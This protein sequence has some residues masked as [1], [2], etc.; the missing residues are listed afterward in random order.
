MSDSRGDQADILGASRS[1]RWLVTGGSGLLGSN[2]ARLLSESGE[3]VCSARTMPPKSPFPFLTANLED[4][5]SRDG[6]VSRARATA[7]FHAGA[8]ASIEGCAA[9]PELAYRINVEAAADLAAQAL[10]NNAAFVYI[11]SDAVFDGTT[12]SYS[13]TS[14]TSPTSEYGR[15]K[16]RG[17][18]AVLNANP[19]ALIARVNFYGWSPTGKR[20]LA[21]FF[22]NR[23]FA[24]Q[25]TPGFTDIAVSTLQVSYLVEALRD[26]VAAGA[27]GIVNVASSESISKFDFGQQLARAFGFNS[28]LVVP[29]ESADH[30]E[31]QRGSNLGLSTELVHRLLNRPMANQRDGLQRLRNERDSDVPSFVKRFNT[32]IGQ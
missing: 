12:G 2:A 16:V 4:A 13:E 15:T 6:L 11:S 22:Y 23:L 26:L 31:F 20:S 32:T 5:A 27:S 29:R 19:N 17:E 21:E 9:V 8:V 25:E 10:R 14:P 1:A 28:D 30:L 3:V 24:G 18:Q 7:V